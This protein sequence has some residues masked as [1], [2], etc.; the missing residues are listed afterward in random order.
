MYETSRSEATLNSKCAHIKWHAFLDQFSDKSYFAHFNT[1]N[2]DEVHWTKKQQKNEAVNVCLKKK[3]KPH[4]STALGEGVY[5]H[6]GWDTVRSYVNITL[7]RYLFTSG[8]TQ[9]YFP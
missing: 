6:R 3:L 1:K 5:H 4:H 8:V 2:T 7:H 9:R